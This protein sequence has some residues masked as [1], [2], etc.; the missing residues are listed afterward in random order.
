MKNAHYSATVKAAAEDPKGAQWLNTFTV[1]KTRVNAAA[2]LASFCANYARMTPTELIR[3]AVADEERPRGERVN[4]PKQRVLGFYNWLRERGLRL[5]TCAVQTAIIRSFYA[6]HGF[7]LKLKA[8]AI[9]KPDRPNRRLRLEPVQ[10]KAMMDNART[11]R[12]RA[13]I[14]TLF[15]SGMDASTLLS[16]K[17]GQVDLSTEPPIRLDLYRSKAGQ[18]YYTFI[19]RD[20]LEAIKAYLADLKTRGIELQPGDPLWLQER[21]RKPLQTHNIQKMLKLVALRTGLIKVDDDHDFN[22]A[23]SHAL[24]ESFSYNLLNRGQM[25]EKY[26]DFLLGHTETGMDRAYFDIN[27]ETIRKEYAAREHLLSVS[28]AMG[29]GELQKKIDAMVNDRTADLSKSYQELQAISNVL[30]KKNIELEDQQK[31]QQEEIARI[32]EELRGILVDL[33][34]L[35]G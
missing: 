19:G 15:Q 20:A 31:R 12:D 25:S 11:P 14:I 26:V 27:Y 6:E 17:R 29:N 30:L 9:A 7:T 4:I 35:A 3:E 18:N 34:R 10:V 21:G 33:K 24:R 23:G 13:V 5:S 2:V 28:T 22:I 16:M 32:K 8:R 1:H